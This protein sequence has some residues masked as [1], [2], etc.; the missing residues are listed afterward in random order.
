MRK[1][2]FAD[3]SGLGVQMTS[4]VAGSGAP[5][6]VD[7]TS[8]ASVQFSSPRGVAWDPLAR[9]SYV[10]DTMNNVIRCVAVRRV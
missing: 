9:Y 5:G 8:G 10:A 2:S 6:S 4:T 1:L 7:G 3:G